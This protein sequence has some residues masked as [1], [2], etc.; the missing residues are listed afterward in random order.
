MK[1]DYSSTFLAVVSARVQLKERS[2][3]RG[4]IPKKPEV[5]CNLATVEDIR[6]LP[7]EGV[8]TKEKL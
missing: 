1:F 5:R 7:L 4:G 2:K 3:I 8:T 6:V